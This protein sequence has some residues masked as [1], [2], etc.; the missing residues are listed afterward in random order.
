MPEIRSAE[1]FVG[2]VRLVGKDRFSWLIEHRPGVVFAEETTTH[3]VLLFFDH[4]RYEFATTTLRME[5]YWLERMGAIRLERWD[6]TARRSDEF[7]RLV[8]VHLVERPVQ[9]AMTN[10]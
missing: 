2:Q 4:T 1:A 7:N 8:E 10:S 9:L 5:W 6:D 3:T